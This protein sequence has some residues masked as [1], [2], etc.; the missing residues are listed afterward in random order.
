[1]PPPLPAWLD[2]LSPAQLHALAQ[3]AQ[4]DRMG[5]TACAT[6]L[7][8]ALPCGAQLQALRWSPLSDHAPRAPTVVL[9]HGGSGSWSH[10]LRTIGALR[11]AGRT[12]WA[13]DLPGQGAS[14]L[15]QGVRDADDVARIL[16]HTLPVWLRSMGDGAQGVDV[17]GFSF[18]ALVAAFWAHEGGAQM[19]IERLV[20]VGAP[21]LGLMP[22]PAYTLRGWQHL[23]EP[24]GQIAAH[25]HNLGALMVHDMGCIDAATLTQHIARVRRDRLPRRRLSATDALAQL[26]PQ[27]PCPV[28][29]IYGEHDALYPTR[30]DMVQALFEQNAS[31]TMVRIAAAGHWVM[32]EQPTALNAALLQ[33]LQS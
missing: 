12:V 16:A 9:L 21:A 7:T 1:M 2:A 25:W 10:W 30:L 24:L 22:R 23:R 29:A 33:A 17:V 8:H 13:L 4:P 32:H 20:L 6:P 5:D 11:R 27:L 26:L 31:G 19:G 18:G 14:D 3:G 28:W 15:P